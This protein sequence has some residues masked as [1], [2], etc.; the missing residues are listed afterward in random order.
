MY[1]SGREGFLTWVRAVPF[2]AGLAI[3]LPRKDEARLCK[4][5]QEESRKSTAAREESANLTCAFPV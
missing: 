1:G 5:V 2:G 4:E 3:S